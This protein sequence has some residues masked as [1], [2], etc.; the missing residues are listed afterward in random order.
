MIVATTKMEKMPKSCKKCSLRETRTFECG[1]VEGVCG[2]KHRICQKEKKPSGN[3]GYGMPD[4]CPLMD[5]YFPE[6][7]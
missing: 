6:D 3:V 2:A 7:E 5:I 1:I 4:W